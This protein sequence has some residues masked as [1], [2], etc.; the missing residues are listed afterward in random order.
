MYPRI[1]D[2]INDLFGTEILLPIKTFGLLM[3]LAFL[4]AYLILRKELR[5]REQAGQ[6]TWRKEKIK[7]DG[8]I[9]LTDVILQTVLW[10]IVG[11][12]LGYVFVDYEL[13][14]NQTDVV[15]MSTK[16]FWLTG[17][18]GM[19]VGGFVRFRQYQAKKEQELVFDERFVGPSYY[20]PTITTI[21][22][23]AG[24]LGSKLFANIENLDA[25]FADPVGN[26]LSFDGLSFFGGLITA[27]FFITRYIHRKGF[28]ILSAMDG[29]APA[30]ILAYAVGRI[31]CQLAGDGD[32]GIINT[33]PQ[34]DW[35]AWL[36]E[37]TWAFDYPHNTAYP[38]PGDTFACHLGL[39]NE[40]IPIA[41]CVGDYCTR[42]KYPVFPT[43]FYETSLG[44]LIFGILWGIRKRLI[45]AG[46]LTGVYLFLIGWER[47]W[48]EQ[49]RINDL[50][51]FLG[52][53]F[54]QAQAI[55][56]AL[57]SSGIILFTW[58]TWRKNAFA[59][60]VKPKEED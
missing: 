18:L 1:S 15:L 49:I 35:L 6:F 55:A 25:F 52:M 26:L 20:L 32:W 47:F 5:R 51:E 54:S 46:Q 57:I 58:V 10:G 23:V 17:L 59:Q 9:S 48:V 33:A 4:V 22:F 45:Y 39:C 42:L 38:I 29:F 40:S 13:F 37:W 34:P 8:P 56:I 60:E 50:Y 28:H 2:L 19:A 21:A 43:P 30:L 12:K 44:V 24:I 11:Y 16:G 53:T 7:L 36:P 27:G 41:D 31:G 14:S 3:A